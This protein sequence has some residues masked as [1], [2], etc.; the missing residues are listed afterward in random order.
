MFERIRMY[1]RLKQHTKGK[2][3]KRLA[4][5]GVLLCASLFAAES[6]KPTYGNEVYV[7]LA[8]IPTSPTAA[9][10][11]TTE[12]REVVLTNTNASTQATVTISCTT[13]GTV[14]VKAV[15]NGV[16]SQNNH[17]VIPYKS[18]LVCAGGVTWGSDVP[19]VNGSIT[20]GQK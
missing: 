17:L 5:A 6:G 2:I 10:T 3:M 9:M 13:S 7:A 4:I 1:V 19:G 18:G 8:A 12:V 14:F 11:A 16:A 20:G 15:L